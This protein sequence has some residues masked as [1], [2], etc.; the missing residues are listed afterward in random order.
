MA[1]GGVILDQPEVGTCIRTCFVGL[2][3]I[4]EALNLLGRDVIFSGSVVVLILGITKRR[5]TTGY[6]LPPVGG[7]IFIVQ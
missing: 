1:V 2:L 7:E 4:I 6:Y 5:G 3:R